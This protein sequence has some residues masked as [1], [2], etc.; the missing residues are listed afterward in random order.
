M[1]SPAGAAD[2]LAPSLGADEGLAESASAIITM[3]ARAPKAKRI[4]ARCGPTAANTLSGEPALKPAV[5]GN[6]A[7]N[8]A[9]EGR[10]RVS[11]TLMSDVRCMEINARNC[12]AKTVLA[13]RIWLQSQNR[14]DRK[15]RSAPC[16]P[17]GQ[18]K[19]GPPTPKRPAIAFLVTPKLPLGGRKV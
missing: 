6:S 4:C 12:G 9:G 17:N 15:G 18:K 11:M 14:L 8:S 19:G 13:N 2:G 5:F 16:D 7:T 3:M 1:E 10:G